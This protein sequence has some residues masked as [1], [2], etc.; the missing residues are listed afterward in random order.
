MNRIWPLLTV[1]LRW[2]VGLFCMHEPCRA[3]RNLLPPDSGRKGSP[4]TLQVPF[5]PTR[6]PLILHNAITT[7]NAKPGDPVY[8][9]T[10]FPSSFTSHF[11]FPRGPT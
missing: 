4:A 6:L 11:D 9:E 3:N 2:P 1:A 8:L 10:V 5:G 7:R